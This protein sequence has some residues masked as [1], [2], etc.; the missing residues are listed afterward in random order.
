MSNMYTGKSSRNP[1]KPLLYFGAIGIALLAFGIYEYTQ[2][3][4]WEVTTDP[5]EEYE[6][7]SILWG[8]Y[9][10]GGK[11]TVLGFFGLLGLGGLYSGWHQTKELKKLKDEAR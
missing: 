10:L 3:A 6:M 7:N 9:D 11:E 5:T 4:A 8:I 1:Y 2:L